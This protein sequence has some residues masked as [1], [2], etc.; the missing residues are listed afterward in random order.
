MTGPTRIKGAQLSL[1]F[2]SPANDYRVDTTAVALD[3]EEADEEVVT[4]ADVADGDA[5]RQYFFQITAV[6][7]TDPTSLWRYIWEHSGDEVAYTY[8]PHGNAEPSESQPHFIGTVEIGPKPSM[9]GEAGASNTFTFETRW[10]VVGTPVLDDGT[11][12]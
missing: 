4:F 8:A 6:Q 5:A 1:K 10:D 7:S 12:S 9:G 2:G 11:G 3:N